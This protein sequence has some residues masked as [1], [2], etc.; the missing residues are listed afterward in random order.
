M[1]TKELP[2]NGISVASLRGGVSRAVIAVGA[3]LVLLALLA[4]SVFRAARLSMVHDEC[5]TYLVVS[6]E[7]LWWA[8]TLN[9]HLLNT[10]CMQCAAWL[11]GPTELAMRSHSLLAHALYLVSSV[12][13]LRYVG[14]GAARVA[15]FA[16]LNL[17]LFTLDFMCLARGYGMGVAFQLFGLFMLLRALHSRSRMQVIVSVALAILSASAAVLA[18]FSFVN[19]FLPAAVVGVALL[20]TRARAAQSRTATWVPVAV[21]LAVVGGVLVF[22]LL[23]VL[24]FQLGEIRWGERGDL[25]MRIVRSLVDAWLYRTD[26]PAWMPVVGTWVVFSLSIGVVACA[27][28]NGARRRAIGSLELV[29]LIGVGSLALTAGQYL[30]LNTV[31]P[32]ERYSLF[33]LPTWLLA[34]TLALGEVGSLRRPAWLA[35]TANAVAVTLAAVAVLRFLTGFSSSSTY[36]WRYD[37]HSRDVLHRIDADR[38]ER[39]PDQQISV[40]NYWAFEPSLNYYRKSLE[41]DWMKPATQSPTT[42]APVGE[43]GHHYLYVLEWQRYGIPENTYSMMQ[44]YPESGTSLLRVEGD[45]KSE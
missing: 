44:H 24:A 40:G 11:F 3:G 19:F 34:V 28:W 21:T 33:F 41:Y 9:H 13:V 1:G 14:T 26:C 42:N 17:N 25:L 31:V 23:R 4:T 43:T 12:L 2:A 45:R 35:W 5:L 22:V 39:Y 7:N 36:T 8:T 37:A 38:R 18:N 20:L 27:I 30:I 29:V 6:S 16:L 10:W 32:T 15:G